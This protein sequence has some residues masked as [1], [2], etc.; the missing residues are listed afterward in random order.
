MSVRDILFLCSFC[1]VLPFC[2]F[3]PFF[4]MLVWT[5]VSTLNPQSFT[6]SLTYKFTWAQAVAI[7]TLAGFVIFHPSWN[8][9]FSRDLGIVVLL[10][11]W[12]TFTTM[13]NTT[14][15]IFSHF[16]GDTWYRWEQVSKIML[17]AVIT[18]L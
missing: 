8:R 14:Q 16:A 5:V 4:G 17:M 3:R 2:F 12:F 10:W 7:P 9:F 6:W 18:V 13:N 15:A 1:A 11:L